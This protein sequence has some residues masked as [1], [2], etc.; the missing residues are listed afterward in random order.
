MDRI[1]RRLRTALLAFAADHDRLEL[2]IPAC[3]LWDCC[4]SVGEHPEASDVD[5]AWWAAVQPDLQLAALE[6]FAGLPL[7]RW[8]ACRINSIGASRWAIGSFG[9]RPVIT[10]TMATLRWIEALLNADVL[11]VIEG[12]AID[13]AL[14]HVMTALQDNEG[15]AGDVD[16]SARKVAR[17]LHAKFQSVGL[18]KGHDLF[19]PDRAVP[20]REVAA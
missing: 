8:E 14:G 6:P 17:H 7:A 20:G 18:Y 13:R 10:M 19:A 5:K 16:K 15:L 12:S 4:R 11:E 9:N 1:E 3:L 2:A